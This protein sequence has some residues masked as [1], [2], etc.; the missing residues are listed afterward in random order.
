MRTWVH[1]GLFFAY[2]AFF[3]PSRIGFAQ[4]DYVGTS[5]ASSFPIAG[6]VEDGDI[7]SFDV[8]TETYTRSLKQSDESVFGIVVDDP[9]L[10]FSTNQV[11][12]DGRPVVRVGEAVVNVSTLKGIIEAGDLVTT[13]SVAGLGEKAPVGEPTYLVG[14]ALE[15][16]RFASTA[17]TDLPG[18][19]RFGRVP[20]ALRMGQHIPGAEKDT[21]TASSTQPLAT[22]PGSV[23]E[24]GLQYFM[25][26]RY[27]LAATVVV[28]SILIALRSFGGALAQ[29]VISVGRNPLARSSIMSMMLWNS[30]F[31]LIVSGVG[32]GIGVAI[33]VL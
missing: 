1:Y 32:L 26:I 14:V 8:E 9:V 10:E 17:R 30:L 23:D 18:T 6:P 28:V 22:G 20:V 21:Q 29:S 13:S 31:I 33:I 19:V 15:D 3:V 11:L 16:M 25:L 24:K 12:P 7:L 5:I 4:T 27:V 2:L